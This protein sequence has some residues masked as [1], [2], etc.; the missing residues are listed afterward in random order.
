MRINLADECRKLEEQMQG[1]TSGP[2][3]RRQEF[4]LRAYAV[5]PGSQWI[6]RPITALELSANGQRVF[7]ERVRS[8]GQVL[9]GD[10]MMALHAG[11][12]VAVSGRRTTLVDVLEPHNSGLREVDDKE[13]LD[14]PGDI[15][16]VV[17]TNA[18]FD[19]RT[20]SELGKEQA[21]RGVFLRRI[22]RAGQPVV[23][24]PETKVH[25][26]DVLTIVG[27]RGQCA[28]CDRVSSASRIARPT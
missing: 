18:A 16:D 1:D 13:L 3:A 4:E 20:L 24:L 26:G 17:V 10:P 23:M 7:V 5:D 2:T 19:G 11:D 21:T 25:R 14:Q 6:G 12:T 28:A 27:S 15:V 9:E 8:R 22:T